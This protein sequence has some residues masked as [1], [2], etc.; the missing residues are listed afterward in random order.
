[1]ASLGVVVE[2]GTLVVAVVK[3]TLLV[4]AV[5]AAAARRSPRALHINRVCAPAMGKW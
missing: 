5:L 1:L 2:V 4:V 3:K